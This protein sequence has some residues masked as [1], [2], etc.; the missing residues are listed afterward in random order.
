MVNI[1]RLSPVSQD[2]LLLLPLS[3]LLGPL[4]ALSLLLVCRQTFRL[5]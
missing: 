3:L 2:L 4:T 1:E 5:T